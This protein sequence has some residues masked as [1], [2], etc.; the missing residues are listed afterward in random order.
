M[1]R[2][3]KKLLVFFLFILIGFSSYA[4]HII[5][6]SLSYEYLGGASYR[7]TLKLYR[8]CFVPVGPTHAPFD[9][10]ALV[11]ICSG[12]GALFTPSRNIS[13]PLVD[14][15]IVDPPIDTCA[16]KPNGICILEANYVAI[17][18]NLPPLTGGYHLFY[19]RYSRYSVLNIANDQGMS[20]YTYIPDNNLV[21]SNSSPKWKNPPPT[22]VCAGTPINFNHGATD[23][24][25]DSL[26]YKFYAPYLGCGAAKYF[27]PNCPDNYPAFPGSNAISFNPVTYVSTYGANNPLDPITPLTLTPTGIING[28]ANILGLFVVGIK[29]EEYRDGVKIGEIMR[30]Y[31]YHV[32]PCPPAAQANF[33]TSSSCAGQNVSFTNT[34]TAGGSGSGSSYFW[35]FGDPTATNDTSILQNPGSY[36]YPGLGPYTATLIINRGSSCVDTFTQVINISYVNAGFNNNDSLCI[37]DSLHFTNTSNVAANATISGYSWNFGDPPSSPNN[38]SALQNPA[39]LFSYAG[40]STTYTVTLIVTSSFGCKDT[41]KKSIT[42]FGVPIVNARDTISCANTGVGITGTVLNAPGGTWTVIPAPGG[43]G[44]FSPS[45]NILTPTY[46]PTANE[47]SQGY[48]TLV[49]SSTGNTK[50]PVKSDTMRINFYA[51]PTANTGPDTVICKGISTINLHGSI[52]VANSAVWSVIMGTTGIITNANSLTGAQFTPSANDVLIG[53]AY[54]QLATLQNGNC[55]P[56]YDTLKITFQNKPNVTATSANDSSCVNSPFQVDG[57]SSTNSGYWTSGGDGTFG[58]INLSTTTYTPGINDATKGWVVLYFNSSNN[59]ACLS[60]KDSVIVTILKAPVANAG[61]DT[62]VC[63]NNPVAPLHGSVSL[64]S[65]SVWSTTGSN[66]GTITKPDS[67]N[68]SYVLSAAEIAQGYANVV[69]TGQGILS[70]CPANSD[71]VRITVYAGPTVA[72]QSAGDSILVCEDTTAIPLSATNTLSTGVQWG[73]GNGTF[74]PNNANST[75]YH[76]TA[77]DVANGSVMLYVQTTGNGLCFPSYD[78]L[79]IVFYGA[80]TVNATSAKDTVCTSSAIP[81]QVSTSTGSGYWTSTGNGIFSPN[82][83]ALIASYVPGNLDGSF[84]SLVFHSDT[85]GCKTQTDTLKIKIIPGPNTNFNYAGACPGNAM[86]FT[87]ASTVNPG[88]I[89]NWQWNFGDTG[90]GSGANPSHT[91]TSSGP[92]NVSLITTSSNGCKDTLSK[93]VTLYNNPVANFTTP[94][95]CLYQPVQLSDASTV[96]GSTI[97]NWNWTM[98]SGHTS[99]LQNP[100]DSFAVQTG[101]SATLIVTSAQGCKDTI[102]KVLNI[103]PQPQAD[104]AASQYVANVGDQISFTNLTPNSIS[105]AWDFHDNS[106]YVLSQNATHIFNLGGIYP[107]ALMIVDVNGCRDTIIKDIT[108][109]LP[110]DVPTGFSPNGD[111]HNDIFYVYGGPFIKCHLRIYN[112]WGELIFESFEQKYGWDG[113]RDGVE[114]PVGVYVWVVDAE[115]AKGQRFN[116]SGD[117]TLLR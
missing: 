28:T 61:P 79:K 16:V 26:V 45:A 62:L 78:S 115:N 1:L 55:M 58:N 76:P 8:D 11:E 101:N 91:Y 41:L 4:T 13:I 23:A 81:V 68:T 47:V 102:T 111:G 36:V 35:D 86:S 84:I 27:G 69:L 50:C 38:T 90:T 14:S 110:P 25:G 92:F 51:G 109:A 32:I 39:H 48:A 108:I 2:L 37:S 40:T 19:Q 72:I 60:E 117:V 46:T 7:I 56:A 105:W 3:S 89:T 42:V 85:I 96:V 83:T 95:I 67:L 93:P 77:T 65:G 54:L 6:G 21:L 74:T 113:R 75:S 10:N 43:P 34:T 82:N 116:K 9:K 29:C 49:L 97:N 103:L 30:D 107:V 59:G 80:P 94:V 63:T 99:T 64:A 104:F 70:S 98:S 106:S 53:T 100:I 18:N 114:Q 88:T 44:T 57:S 71:T 15:S 52:T 20:L 87:D 33:T 5:G 12:N 73:G 66:P 22:F 24:D 17:V 31:Q 112:N